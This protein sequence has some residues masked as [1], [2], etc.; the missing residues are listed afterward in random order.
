[1]FPCLV[2]LQKLAIHLALLLPR[3]TDPKEKQDK[4]IENLRLCFPRTWQTFVRDRSKT[5]QISRTEFC[6]KWK[7]LRRLLDFWH[8]NG[9]KVLIFSHSVRLLKLLKTLFDTEGTDYN[10][11]YLDG[12]MTPNDRADAV[13]DF[14]S[15]PDQFV[16]LISAKAGGVGLNIT[17]AN[18]V[19]VVDPHWN[20]AYDLQAQDRAYRIGQTRDVEVFRLVSAGTIEEIIYA[21]QIYKQQQANIGYTASTERRYFK[22]VMDN[23]NKSGEL[24]GL[25][26]IFN[27]EETGLLLRDIVQKTNIAET[28]AGVKMVDFTPGSGSDIEDDEDDILSDANLGIVPG[29]SADDD[30]SSQMKSLANRLARGL[31]QSNDKA[32]V[33]NRNVPDPVN[34]ILAR[35]GVQYTHNNSEVIGR[36]EIEA[37]LGR[38]AMELRNDVNF[39]SK[40]VFQLSQS[41]SQSQS[42][43]QDLSNITYSED[44]DEV[45]FLGSGRAGSKREFDVKYKFYPS[46]EVKNRQFCSIAAM[47]GYEDPLEFAKYVEMETTAAD[48]KDI[49]ERFYRSRRRDILNE[50]T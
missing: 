27:F 35:A 32:K 16:F 43:A 26:N 25:Q 14:N 34:A 45:T 1:M 36:S 39:A 10:F 8:A 29:K 4:D 19:V 49:L 50:L 20:P 15:N 37:E 33:E 18:K 46:T 13:A 11:S 28:R 3:D 47:M 7:V 2:T 31:K 30:D 5:F 21:R 44:E 9:D 40:A 48:R 17:S 22:G 12:S 41:Q 24:F 38:Q 6:G 23:A 42:R